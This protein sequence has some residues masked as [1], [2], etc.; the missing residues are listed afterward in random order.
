MLQDKDRIF[1]NL[2]GQHD[3]KLAGAKQRGVWM[4]TGD[5]LAWA[6]TRCC[7]RS[8]TPACAGAAAPVFPPA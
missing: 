6:A 1:T 4:G 7:R 2:Y 8:R 5:M 3:W